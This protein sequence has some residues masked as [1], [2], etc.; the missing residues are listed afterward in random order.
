[1][2]LKTI[3]IFIIICCL[4]THL[5]QCIS[6][7]AARRIVH[8]GNLLPQ[9]QLERLKIGMSKHDVAILLGTSLLSPSFNNERW[10]YTYTHRKGM[11]ALTT[12]HASL[13]FSHNRLIR[14][15][16]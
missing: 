6:Y 15:E 8:Q 7:D 12:R 10:D 2:R 14:I 13:Y 16:K 1:M 5:T 3:I 4:S 11:G 9:S